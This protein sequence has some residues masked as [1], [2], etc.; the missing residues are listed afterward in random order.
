[1][2]DNDKVT[3]A[4]AA[5]LEGIEYN[6]MVIRAGRNNLGIHGETAENGGRATVLI[7][8]S[9]LSEEAQKKYF[10]RKKDA[11]LRERREAEDVPWYVGISLDR[12][13]AKYS[14]EYHKK[15]AVAAE[16]DKYNSLKK[17]Y[18]KETTEFAEEFAA[19]HLQVSGRQLRR[20][21]SAYNEGCKWAELMSPEGNYDY[22]R[23][24]ALCRRPQTGKGTKLT[25]EMKAELNRLWSSELYHKNLQNFTTLYEEFTE[26]LSDAEFIPS[27]RTCLKYIRN[28]EYEYGNVHTLLKSGVR[29]FRHDNMMKMKRDTGAL[30]V[31]ELVQ[32]DAHTFDTWVEYTGPTGK[33][34]AIRPYLVGFIDTRSRA[35]VGWGVCVVPNAEVIKQVIIHMI[36]DKS[37]SDISGVPKVLYLDNGKDFTAQTLTGHPRTERFELDCNL[38]GFYGACGIEEYKRALPYTPWSKAQI[39]RFFGTLCD[40]FSK[41]FKAYTGTLTGSRTDAKVQKDIKEMLRRGELPTLTEFT[42][43][44]EKWLDRYHNKVHSGL[45]DQGEPEPTPYKVFMNAPRY[46]KAA[47]PYEYALT[48]LGKCEERRVT[49]VGINVNGLLYSNSELGRYINERVTVRYH[50]IDKSFICVYNSVSGELICRAYTYEYMPINSAAEEDAA[51]R[52]KHYKEQS[53]QLKQTREDLERLKAGYEKGMCLPGLSDAPQRVVAIPQ[54]S[55]FVARAIRAAEEPKRARYEN[56]DFIKGQAAKAI[57][58]LKKLG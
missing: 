10:R 17:E 6:S 58:R 38:K 7:N 2:D 40:Q 15:C 48:M 11:E 28:L 25:E 26:G 29:G 13:M 22:Y 5:E 33:K 1:M 46:E 31:L 50:D 56:N 55:Q 37:G 53:H 12:Y 57:E 36:Y 4:E 44:F 9:D 43:E 23:I 19:E 16:L 42:A 27:Y 30:E 32:G 39:E 18:P 35:L 21:L 54:D 8:V 45:K 51:A 49:N 3:L 14:K 47:P 41:K 34:T 20:L 24:L 52:L